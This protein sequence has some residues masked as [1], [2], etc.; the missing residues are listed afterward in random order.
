[1]FN[2]ILNFLFIPKF[3]I[4]G[5]AYSTLCSFFLGMVVSN[6]YLGW[7]GFVDFSFFLILKLI[8]CFMIIVFISRYLPEGADYKYSVLNI[9]TIFTLT[10]TL[11]A[12]SNYKGLKTRFK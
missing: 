10:I 4:I 1:M 2:V 6:Y 8:L 5:A 7:R 12:M 11:Y 9:L 3:G